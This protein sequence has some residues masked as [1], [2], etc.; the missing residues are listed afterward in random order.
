[1][2]MTPLKY[3]NSKAPWNRGIYL[4]STSRLINSNNG[5]II[6]AAKMNQNPP[7]H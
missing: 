4:Y 3:G 2:L 6:L 1:M 7:M 5:V